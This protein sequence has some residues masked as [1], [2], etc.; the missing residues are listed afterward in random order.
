MRTYRG[1]LKAGD[2]VMVIAGGNS[3]K[4]PL[5]GQVGKIVR[6]SKD[7]MRVLVEGVNIVT[8][9][10]KPTSMQQQ[11]GKVQ[12]EAPISVSN[13]MYYVEKAKKPVRLKVNILTDGKK[14]RG[15]IDPKS[16]EFVQ[17]D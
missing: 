9:Y 6:F 7:G 14:V 12:T 5:K 13:V 16:K 17:L 4:R 10:R 3:K 1:F 8:K 2:P 11:G 15:Y